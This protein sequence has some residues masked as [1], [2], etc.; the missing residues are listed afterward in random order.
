MWWRRLFRVLKLL[1]L[2]VLFV[3]AVAPEWP[4]FGD[5]EHQL[6]A[7]IG[8]REFDFVVWE[9]N[10]AAAK[11]DAMLANGQ[12]YLAEPA[13]RQLALDYLDLMR[14]ARQLES[15]IDAIFAD[16]GVDDPTAASADLRAQL[17]DTRAGMAQLQPTAEAIVQDQVA[18]VLADEGFTI[19]GQT[20]PPVLMH[21][22][23]LPAILIVS[24]RDRIERTEGIPLVHGL[25]V[26][27]YE[28]METAVHDNLDMSALAVPIGGLGVYPAMI[29]ETGS[30]NWLAEVTAHEWAHHWLT[31]Y[32]VNLK[33]LT[34]PQIRTI[35]ETV[36]SILGVEVGKQVIERFYPEFVPP[37]PEGDSGKGTAVAPEPPVFDF[38]AE[39]RET[40]VHVDELL[41]QG[42]I[43][44][45]EAYMEAR[46]V[47]FWEN[48][49]R[50][51]KLNQAYF[52]F[53]GAYA[54]E[55]GAT[56]GDP[57][58]PMLLAIREHSPSLKAFM[59]AIS[60]IRDYGD[61]QALYGEVVGG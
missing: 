36:A 39:M 35:N 38:R 24:P 32:P 61:L 46:R 26:T 14:Q 20:F 18:A 48:G 44:E 47:R 53:Y 21:M 45:A 54:D 6:D 37:E 4:A 22:T 16:P 58:G 40:R 27:A 59:Q 49:Y 5:P 30:I 25:A 56:G 23:P 7:I 10:A 42:K 12:S 34:D 41:A 31:P 2:T 33:Y 8:L 51:R 52:A 57:I 28:Q 1:V 11:L 55:P 9:T 50:I 3:T 13:R 17:A 19:L 15:G 29:M 43:D 60:G